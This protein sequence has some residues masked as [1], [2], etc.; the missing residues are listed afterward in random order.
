MNG[1]SADGS[2][3]PITRPLRAQN[4]VVTALSCWIERRSTAFVSVSPRCRNVAGFPHAARG[5]RRRA[6][7]GAVG[8]VDRAEHAEHEEAD[9]ATNSRSDN[10]A[11]KGSRRSTRVRDPSAPPS[12]TASSGATWANTS[13]A[14]RGAGARRA[15]QQ[16]GMLVGRPERDQRQQSEAGRRDFSEEYEREDDRAD[17][18]CSDLRAPARQRAAARDREG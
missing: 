14:P 9:E 4:R 1:A 12:T 17:G 16:L 11:R 2:L 8:V 3:A 5:A 18:G 6:T 13:T 10:A 15:A 7:P